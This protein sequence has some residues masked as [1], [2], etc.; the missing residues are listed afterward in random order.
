VVA[1]TTAAGPPGRLGLLV[2]DSSSTQYLVD[3]G[4]VY[5]L[6]PHTSSTPAD[7]PALVS[8]DKSPVKC[9]GATYMQVQVQNK[10]FKWRFLLAAVAFPIIGGDFLRHFD[11]KVDLKRLRLE[12]GTQA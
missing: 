5:S 10:V 1:T 4:S 2:D 12:H 6:L 3:T 11:L 7:G 9:W 8:A